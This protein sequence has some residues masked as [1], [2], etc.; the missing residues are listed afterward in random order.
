M[1][2]TLR[3]ALPMI[4]RP[5]RRRLAVSACLALAISLW[6]SIAFALLYF[7]LA[8]ASGTRRPP[9]D[10]PLLGTTRSSA[11]SRLALIVVILMLAKSFSAAVLTRWQVHVQTDF[12]A[13]L[14][15]KVFRQ[16]MAK[17]LQRHRAE[18][19]AIF[20]R[21]ATASIGQ[22]STQV[23]GASQ[24]MVTDCSLLLAIF[25]TLVV[26]VPVLASSFAVFLTIVVLGYM[27]VVGPTIRRAAETDQRVY[28]GT[29]QLMQQA[30]QGIK[31]VLAFDVSNI[32]SDE[33]EVKRRELSRA[34][35]TMYFTQRLPQ[36]YLEVCLVLGAAA[37]VVIY[38][39][40]ESGKSA[41][42]VLVMLVAAVLRALPSVSRLMSSFSSLRAGEPAVR[43][44]VTALDLQE[45]L[46]PRPEAQVD[47]DTS[48][49]QP[50]PPTQSAALVMS[51]VSMTYRGADRPAL[52]DI[53][54]TIE[55]GQSIGIVGPSGAG[56]T[57]LVDVLLGLLPAD[58][59][60]VMLGPL[61]VA[62]SPSGAWRRQ[63]G[64]VPQE[65]FLLDESIR[66]N[67]VFFRDAHD[68]KVWEAL[69][70]ARLDGFVLGLA[71]GLDTLVGENGARLSGGQRQRLGIARALYTHPPLL[72]FDEAT[73]A[74]DGK[75]EAD[76]M[77]TMS[78]LHGSI[79][80]VTIAHRLSTVRR[81][82]IVFVLDQGRIVGRG[83]FS[84]LAASEGVFAEML[85]HFTVA[86]EK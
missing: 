54:L 57:T 50:V 62:S 47:V 73:S 35:A 84:D 80:S 7:T 28:T 23:V 32:I 14:A 18:N 31:T 86:T 4:D 21:N 74:L 85:Q 2:E 37:T 30:A 39:A 52:T 3:L 78:E 55:P 38:N 43:N 12:E 61:S 24:T 76:L 11:E 19:S 63:V 1:L 9:T 34:H 77:A 27:R 25:V 44:L 8:I 16:H 5:T 33:Y 59:G 13:R 56:K 64:Y 17:D 71:N 60:D 49:H 10:I 53:S 82:D 68:D 58:S 26:L 48:E 65:T 72:I 29:L 6:E 81:C 51:H 36:F 75:T 15:S 42:V 69:R 45:S 70:L 22:V 40:V 83:R 79:T 66:A 20:L 41:T 46:Q 67:I